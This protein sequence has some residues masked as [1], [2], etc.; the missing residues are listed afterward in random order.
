ML[1]HIHIFQKKYKKCENRNY[2]S[3]IS[4]TMTQVEKTK[5]NSRHDTKRRYECTLVIK[6]PTT[7]SME[8]IQSEI[9]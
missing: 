5:K 8:M 2:K 3:M 7:K 4:L 6:S 9:D 1:K